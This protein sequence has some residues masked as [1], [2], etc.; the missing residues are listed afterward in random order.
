[1]LDAHRDGLKRVQAIV[2]LSH[3]APV[4]AE[5]LQALE[6]ELG[7]LQARVAALEAGA[8]RSAP[9]HV[10]DGWWLLAGL[11]VVAAVVG[12]RRLLGGA[13]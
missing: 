12:R 10:A 1:M 9:F 8:P 5:R 13:R 6:G 11:A 3:T 2:G 4:L 7:A